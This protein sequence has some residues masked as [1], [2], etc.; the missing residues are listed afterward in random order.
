[1]SLKIISKGFKRSVKDISL[2]GIGE[3]VR[4]IPPPE[5]GK[6][7]VSYI[8][9]QREYS[10]FKWQMWQSTSLSTQNSHVNENK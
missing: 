9:I 10:F 8:C 1:M 3:A 7:L 6:T 5:N 2:K 4:G